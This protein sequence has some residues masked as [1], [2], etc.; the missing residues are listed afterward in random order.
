MDKQRRFAEDRAAPERAPRW[1]LQGGRDSRLPRRGAG[2]H[3]P[4]AQMKDSQPADELGILARRK[5]EAAVIA[6]IY[7]EM[8]KALGEAKAREILGAAIRRAAV[9]AG[10]EMAKRVAR[11]GGPRKLQVDPASVDQ[12]RRAGDRGSGRRARRPR[13]Q[14]HALPL[15]RDLPGHGPRRRSATCSPATV[16]ARS[17]KA[18][19]RAST[20]TR[21]QTIMGGASHCDF[22]YRVRGAKRETKAQG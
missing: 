2:M 17:A 20:L 19:I 21:T 4:G 14:R 18:T 13:F 1:R 6:P 11:R 12:G 22:R 15:R 3:E 8:R 16:T 5:I 10:A 7:D 9:A